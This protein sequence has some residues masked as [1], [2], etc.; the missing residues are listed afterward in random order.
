MLI[1]FV[2]SNYIDI[3]FSNDIKKRPHTHTDLY[4]MKMSVWLKY[5]NK[6]NN[7]K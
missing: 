1:L 5:I 6:I 2:Y 4:V 3:R 7:W